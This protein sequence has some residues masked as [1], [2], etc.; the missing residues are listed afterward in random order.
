M[1]LRENQL[2]E[3]LIYVVTEG[4]SIMGLPDISVLSG[5]QP[6][7]KGTREPYVLITRVGSNRKG[8]Q[9]THLSPS[10]RTPDDRMVKEEW[11]YIEDVTYQI[12]GVKR[13]NVIDDGTPT[14]AD[15]VG[16]VLTYLQS[17]TG[18]SACI[19]RGMHQYRI[20][21]LRLPVSADESEIPQY[22]PNF[23]VTFC[24]HQTVDLA[25]QSMDFAGVETHP[26]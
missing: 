8:W 20:S 13:R 24:V 18:I 17:D 1:V 25:V 7:P 11:S 16:A 9:G 6:S 4:L 12:S 19:K 2:S 21:E 3:R 15:I 23:D 5:H 10:H 22:N 26:I 14:A